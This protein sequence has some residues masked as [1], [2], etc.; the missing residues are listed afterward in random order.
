MIG[1]SAESKLAAEIGK[2]AE[3]RSAN[4][5]RSGDAIREKCRKTFDS[6]IDSSTWT[7][8]TV[9]GPF[10]HIFVPKD[11]GIRIEDQFKHSVFS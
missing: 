4:L 3:I 1:P 10:V 2:L 11:V 6:R 9:R 8:Q 5:T 7:S